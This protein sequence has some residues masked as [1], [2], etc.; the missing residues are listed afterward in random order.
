ML[1]MRD[2]TYTLLN[3]NISDALNGRRILISRGGRRR[4]TGTVAGRFKFS[5]DHN[6]QTPNCAGPAPAGWLRV[7]A[8]DQYK[9]HLTSIASRLHIKCRQNHGPHRSSLFYSHIAV[10][11]TNWSLFRFCGRRE[12]VAKCLGQIT[13]TNRSEVQAELKQVISDAFSARTLWTTDWPAMQLQRFSN[14]T[15]LIHW[16]SF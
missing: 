10:D 14:H 16:P 4:S 7:P 2:P 11:L 3:L 13:D 6:I 5:G 15:L 12:W 8:Y 9:Y 1:L